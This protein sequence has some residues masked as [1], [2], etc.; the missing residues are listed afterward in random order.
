MRRGDL[1]KIVPL[2]SAS[3]NS[4]GTRS[5]LP[6]K[7]EKRAEAPLETMRKEGWGRYTAD[8]AFRIALML[9]L[10][11]IGYS[12]L[13][14]SWTV[15]SQYEDLIAFAENEHRS[16]ILFGTFGTLVEGRDGEESAVA[17][18][19]LIT[20]VGGLGSDLDDILNTAGLKSSEVTDVAVVN[21]S[22][23]AASLI[24]RASAHGVQSSR[25]ARMATTFAVPE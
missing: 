21:A 18:L 2:S 15:R 3:F 9:E 25:F 14:A 4:L 6:L 5:L 8:D 1:L 19:P 24:G 7:G 17:K 12:Q 20:T 11:R 23:V 22:K 16:P 10:G 13:T